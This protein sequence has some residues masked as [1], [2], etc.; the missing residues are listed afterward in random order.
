MTFST[1][2]AKSYE[3]SIKQNK[4][5][6][7]CSNQIISL[8]LFKLHIHD[9]TFKVVHDVMM[10]TMTK[11]KATTTTTYSNVSTHNSH[12]QEKL[13]GPCDNTAH[14][15]KVNVTHSTVTVSH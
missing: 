2:L 4:L 7:F 8:K 14:I 5:Y 6:L 1:S 12:F 9:G 11:T 15:S 3:E 13:T 10:T